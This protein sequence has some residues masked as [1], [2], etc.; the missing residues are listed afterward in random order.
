M[1]W[2]STACDYYEAWY[3]RV[4]F[5]TDKSYRWRMTKENGYSLRCVKD[6]IVAFKRI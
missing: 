3:R 5:D 2:S 1:F 4:D 6:Y